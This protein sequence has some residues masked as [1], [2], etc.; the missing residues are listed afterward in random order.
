MQL[1][2][3]AARQSIGADRMNPPTDITPPEDTEAPPP[4]HFIR[5][6]LAA[7]FGV[8]GTGASTGLAFVETLDPYVKFAAGIV[9]LL[10]GAATFVYYGLAIAEK[11][12]NLRATREDE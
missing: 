3:G 5:T 2:T 11:W 4:L 6:E 10:V 1:R 8:V 9:A 12:R 7:R